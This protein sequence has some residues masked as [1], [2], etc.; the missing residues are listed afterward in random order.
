MNL[1]DTAG[2]RVSGADPDSLEAFER[3]CRELRCF[4]GDPVASATAAIERSPGMTM[5][6][7]LHAY[8]H[9]LGTEPG[10]LPAARAS[11]EAARRL[12]ANDRERMHVEAVGRLC[13]GRWLDAGRVLEDLSIEHPRDALALQAGHQVDFFTGRSRMLRDRIARALPHWSADVPGHHAVLGM[14]AFGLEECGDYASAEAQGRRAVELEPRDGWAW[15]AVAHAMEMQG[16]VHDGIR[17]LGGGRD[18][19]S[20][21]SSF[22]VHNWWHLALFHLEAG[23]VD[24][25]LALFDGPI[26]GARSGVVLDLVD[27]SALLWRLS[28]RGVD[29]GPR[30]DSVADLWR[31]IAEASDYA[32]NDWHATMAF[33]GSG[34]TDAAD[35]VEA[36]QRRAI[37]GDG[38]NAAFVREVGAS[39][40]AAFRAFGDGRHGDALRLLRPIREIA[41]RFGGSHAQRDLIDLTIVEAARRAG[42]H[43]LAD[44]LSI[45]RRAA[46]STSPLA[47]LSPR[48]PGIAVEA[49][50]A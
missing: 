8:L 10:G 44:A 18:T 28:L 50:A 33:V 4:V 43:A 15:H 29:V 17:W 47:V 31:P 39:A 49:R 22:A 38:D 24:A 45:E 46:K 9:L 20:E 1:K 48:R 34:R 32:F 14:H 27:A 21:G 25:V 37:A 35:A 12:P 30:W 6:H 2:H 23:D 41:H 16:R 36:A 7:V 3:G 26:H 19:W 13:E 11:H 40:C 5:A 42:R